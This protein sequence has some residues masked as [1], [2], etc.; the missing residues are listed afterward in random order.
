MTK[1]A[2][3]AQRHL[4]RG[5]GTSTTHVQTIDGRWLDIAVAMVDCEC[6]I[7]HCAV[8]R[9]IYGPDPTGALIELGRQLER[10]DAER[11]T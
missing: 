1:M 11:T 10:L 7:V 9:G 3:L 6:G 5:A 8:G 2:P 4:Y